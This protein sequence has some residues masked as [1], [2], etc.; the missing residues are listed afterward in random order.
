[1]IRMHVY[2]HIR[3]GIRMHVLRMCS[4]DVFL[5]K[6]QTKGMTGG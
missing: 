6:T 2:M 4:Q 3:I 5:V 1:M